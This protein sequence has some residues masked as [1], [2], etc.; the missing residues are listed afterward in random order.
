MSK[1]RAESCLPT[2]LT[3]R[4]FVCRTLLAAG[5][6][7]LALPT[8]AR[9]DPQRLR[10][11]IIGHTGKGN[12]GHGLDAVF[13]DRSNIEVVAVADADAE[14][15]EQAKVRCG[16][17]R[18]DADY[19]E[20]LA[21][22]KPDLVCV[23]PR[24]TDE[25]FA[26]ARAALEAGAHLFCEKPFTQ[27]LLEADKLLA[28][29][30]QR[31]RKI[32]VAHQMRSSPNIVF[33]KRKLDQG[34]IGDLLEIRAHGKQDQRAGG[35]D[36]I[37]LGTHLFDLLRLFA[38]EPDWC[39]AR[40]LQNGREITRADVRAASEGIGPVVGDAIFAHFAFPNGVNA[41]F[42]SRGDYRQTAGPWGL[43]LIGTKGRVRI[44]A[45]LW[46]EVWVCGQ[47]G[48]ERADAA[49]DW[50]R[51][52]GD[53]TLSLQPGEMTPAT[54]NARLVDDWLA[55]LVQDREPIC[56]GFNGMKAVEMALAVFEAGLT[57]GRVLLPMMRRTH[58]L[59]P[60]QP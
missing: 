2:A 43:E 14:G 47:R 5:G 3:R 16:A 11:A 6:L 9:Q 15:R 20:M 52:E 39:S 56:S 30:K 49:R 55:A 27:S 38:G 35:E 8:R 25:H 37:V 21:R 17:K 48:P 18:A 36:L 58:P 42:Q 57:R 51:L 28:V 4:Q 40:V 44:K 29:A 45:N 50:Q 41:T 26:M 7:S 34:L 53:P 59:C 54:A 22:E 19:Q 12:Y 46:P 1:M 13:N 33:L 31:G 10:A 32:A 60:V 24:W 23:A